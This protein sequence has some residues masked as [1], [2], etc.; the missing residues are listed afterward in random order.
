MID[1]E[2]QNT[3]RKEYSVHIFV[4]MEKVQDRKIDHSDL[5]YKRSFYRLIC[6]LKDTL[7]TVLAH[8]VQE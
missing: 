4:L 7:A 3:E 5:E 6:H 2:E 1:W 8:F